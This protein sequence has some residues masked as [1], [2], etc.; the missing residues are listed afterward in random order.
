MVGPRWTRRLHA[1][2]ISTPNSVHPIRLSLLPA[3]AAAAADGDDDDDDDDDAAERESTSECLVDRLYTY[4]SLQI[5]ATKLNPVA[6]T[7]TTYD[8][9]PHA[10]NNPVQLQLLIIHLLTAASFSCTC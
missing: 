7:R 4:D 10:P 8:L 5:I 3:A 2:T 1:S 6:V 9:P